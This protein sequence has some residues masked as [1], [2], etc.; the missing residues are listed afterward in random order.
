HLLIDISKLFFQKDNNKRTWF[1]ADQILHFITILAV[2]AWAYNVSFDFSQLSDKTKLIYA[3]S[4]LFLITPSS[5]IIKTII[6][7]W[8]P[9][10]VTGETQDSL[11][12]AGKLIG[13]LERLL[14]FAFVLLGKWEG[15]GFLLAAKS[16]FRFGDLKD[17]K[18]MKL[19][20]YVLIG[21]LLS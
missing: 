6:S 16:V 17:A 4:I 5:V 10:S 8:S 9:A 15:V 11:Q 21:T 1:F 20:E 7:K 2:W 3:V 18:D 14:V 12:N 19:T 13:I